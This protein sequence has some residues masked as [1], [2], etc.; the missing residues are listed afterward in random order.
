[1]VVSDPPPGEKGWKIEVANAEKTPQAP[2]LLFANRA[3]STS[4]DTEQFVDIGGLRYSHILDPRTG[5]ALTDRI[6]VTI[7]APNGLTSD[8]LSK[9]VSVLGQ[10]KGEP[11]VHTYPNV[12]VFVRF[13][14]SLN[15]QNPSPSGSQAP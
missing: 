12:G 3:I 9:V 11:I 13:G 14:G 5:Q 15:P 1:M 4:G 10:A 2:V 8:S 6:Q 7:T